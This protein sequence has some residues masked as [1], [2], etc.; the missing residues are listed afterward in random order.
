MAKQLTIRGVSEELSAQLA[1][2]SRDR[3]QSLNAT[4][5]QIHEDAL[6][7]DARRERLQR[8]ATWSPNDQR[9]FDSALAGQRVVDDGLW[10]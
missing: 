6:G 8:Y 7:V 2:L 5:L 4:A 10:R 9:E 1:R 3:G